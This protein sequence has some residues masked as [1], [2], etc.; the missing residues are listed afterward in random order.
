MF[1][2]KST[3][4]LG[5]LTHIIRLAILLTFALYFAVPILW[6][7]MAPSKDIMQMHLSETPLAFGS[8]DRLIKSWNDI[9]TYQNGEIVLWFGNSVKYSLLSLLG[10]LAISIPAGYVLAV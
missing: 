9:F 6:L 2:R 10:S 5:F 4:N 3:S 1:R 7:L 8:I